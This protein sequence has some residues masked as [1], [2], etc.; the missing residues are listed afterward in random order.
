MSAVKV[1]KFDINKSSN[2]KEIQAFLDANDITA[3]K[4]LK[5]VTISRNDDELS[6]II[7]WSEEALSPA[8]FDVAIEE[9]ESQATRAV[10]DARIGTE[11][12]GANNGKLIL[13]TGIIVNEPV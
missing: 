4:V 11:D 12:D 3:G 9:T 2:A 5:I 8:S 10:I 1:Q 6:V 7:F 13:R